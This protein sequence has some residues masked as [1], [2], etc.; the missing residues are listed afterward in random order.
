M[1]SG[2]KPIP[3]DQRNNDWQI[4]IP[5]DFNDTSDLEDS[6][7]FHDTSDLED[8]DNF[9]ENRSISNRHIDIS[10]NIFLHYDTNNVDTPKIDHAIHTLNKQFLHFRH[11]EKRL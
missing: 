8:S 2:F 3:S 6:E 11:L 7:D 5:E 9:D 4:D 10:D 1:V